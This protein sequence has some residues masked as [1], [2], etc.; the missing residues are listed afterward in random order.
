M[1]RDE[2]AQPMALPRGFSESPFQLPSCRG[3]NQNPA[4]TKLLCL[5]AAAAITSWVG[6]ASPTGLPEAG[7]AAPTAIDCGPYPE[8]YEK[9]I[10]AYFAETL[11]EPES[12]QYRMEKPYAGQWRAG[13]VLGAGAIHGGYIVDLA[14]R[15]KNRSGGYLPE[16]PVSVFI[17]NGAVLMELSDAEMKNVH[18]IG[19]ES[20]AALPVSK[21]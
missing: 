9:L 20:P 19:A 8:N 3:S 1:L 11:F 13:R 7:V 10:K 14:I 12:A 21:G 17:R 5:L 18:R 6:C 16:K 4:M 15:A 2:T